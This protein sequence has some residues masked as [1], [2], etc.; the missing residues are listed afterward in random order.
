MQKALLGW[1]LSIQALTMMLIA[2]NAWLL[3][4]WRVHAGRLVTASGGSKG[5][6]IT[7]QG[8]TSSMG[9]LGWTSLYTDLYT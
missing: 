6:E 8:K 1:Y 3:V 7:R 2:L 4:L 9:N 5:G